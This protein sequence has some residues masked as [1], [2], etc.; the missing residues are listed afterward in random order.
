MERPTHDCIFY[1]HAW[2]ARNPDKRSPHESLVRFAC[3]GDPPE[4]EVPVC[5]DHDDPTWCGEGCIRDAE[6]LPFFLRRQAD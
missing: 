6:I 5:C 3:D 4:P 2:L 1:P